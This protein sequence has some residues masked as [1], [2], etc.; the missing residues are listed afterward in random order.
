MVGAR[1]VLRHGAEM[2]MSATYHGETAGIAAAMATLDILDREDVTGHVWRLGERLIDGLNAAARAHGLPAEAY[3]EP[4]PPMPF[5]RFTHPD[6]ATNDRL[7]KRFYT[8]VIRAGVLLHPR[9][10][11]FISHAHRA[12]DIEHT[13]AVA[14]AAMARTRERVCADP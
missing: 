1:E 2:H 8:E 7:R 3:G 11:W 10:L 9:H 6:P 13:L 4:L 14:D 5:M 12:E